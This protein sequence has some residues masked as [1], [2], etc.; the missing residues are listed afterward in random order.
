MQKPL[1]HEPS[2][3]ALT[4]D[5][6][7]Q[8]RPAAQGSAVEQAPPLVGGPTSVGEQEVKAAAA[9]TTTTAIKRMVG[10]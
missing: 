9:T 1:V 5:P 10:V 2:V 3:Q 4:Q 6:S 7:A 8:T